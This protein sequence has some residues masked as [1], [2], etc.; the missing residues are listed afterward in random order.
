MGMFF[1]K[2]N[3]P[4][5]SPT[6]QEEDGNELILTKTSGNPIKVESSP[7]ELLPN[8][9]TVLG[10]VKKK[11]QITRLLS[12]SK[13]Y[14]ETYS[15]EFTILKGGSVV[16]PVSVR[17]EQEPNFSEVGYTYQFEIKNGIGRFVKVK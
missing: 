13:E 4:F 11:I 5:Y 14:V 12:L 17:W 9:Y 7:V 6:S 8:I 2:D 1:T 16:F 10:N 15:G 3:K